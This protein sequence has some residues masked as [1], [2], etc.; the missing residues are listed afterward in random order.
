MNLGHTRVA[1]IITENNVSVIFVDKR[2]ISSDVQYEDLAAS[3][4]R[5]LFSV[6]NGARL[7]IIADLDDKSSE[8]WHINMGSSSQLRGS[9][10]YSR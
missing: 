8:Q 9:I 2:K 10:H 6:R 4:Y 7:G 5:T 1:F 3:I